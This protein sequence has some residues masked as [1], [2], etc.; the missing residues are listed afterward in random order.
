MSFSKE[1]PTVPK[2]INTPEDQA[3]VADQTNESVDSRS[4]CAPGI[5]LIGRDH[6]LS[7]EIYPRLNKDKSFILF[8]QAGIGKTALLQWSCD[9]YSGGHKAYFSCCDRYGDC[10]KRIA[11]ALEIEGASKKSLAVL[12][13]EILGSNAKATLFID[14]IEEIKP[15]MINFLKAVP[16]WIKFY[17]SKDPKL[18]ENF[19]PC[20]WSVKRI[21]VK[22]LSKDDT[23]SLVAF[24][25]QQTGSV[26]DAESVVDAV[27]G[28]PGRI[29]ACC[30][31][32]VLRDDD[33]VKGEEI[34]I[35]PALIVFSVAGFIALRYTGKAAGHTDWYLVGG[36]GMGLALVVRFL[37]AK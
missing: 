32:E 33:H 36:V 23:R 31:G 15:Q 19:K 34:N 13:R 37:F 27:K 1:R 25:I 35:L 20:V 18:K 16:E 12:E 21:H 3:T 24:A 22:P 7:R 9:H 10:V 26:I 2:K 30:R 6:L 29:W 17:A 28:I 8:G 14:N 11:A 4:Q 5:R